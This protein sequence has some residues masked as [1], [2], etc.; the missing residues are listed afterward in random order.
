MPVE[1][2]E[3]A[4][5]T[6]APA[7]F[8]FSRRDDARVRVWIGHQNSPLCQPILVNPLI[9]AGSAQLAELIATHCPDIGAG[10]S[11]RQARAQALAVAALG[12]YLTP[13]PAPRRPRVA[14]VILLAVAGVLVLAVL[15][16]LL[17]SLL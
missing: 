11:E 8:V 6:T 2:G 1:R 10:P 16:S 4:I 15:L 12:V 7:R 17:R 13:S 14:L 3:L 5:D 9:P